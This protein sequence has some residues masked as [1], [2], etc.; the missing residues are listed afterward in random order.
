VRSVIGR[1]VAVN[2]GLLIAILRRTALSLLETRAF[3]LVDIGVATG[4]NL[5]ASVTIPNGSLYLPY[6]DLFTPYM[7]GTVM[8]WTAL[9]GVGIGLVLMAAAA[10]PLQLAMAWLNGLAPDAIK[11][12]AVVEGSLAGDQLRRRRHRCNPCPR[13]RLGDSSRSIAGGARG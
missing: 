6:H 12:P 13:G 4:L 1:V 5:W 3:L 10:L 2:A 8:L 11:W 7:W 9:R